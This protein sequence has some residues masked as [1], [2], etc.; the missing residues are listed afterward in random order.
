[1]RF[2]IS[3]SIKVGAVILFF[4]ILLFSQGLKLNT[5]T[6]E[7]KADDKKLF[8]IPFERII[9]IDKRFD[10]SK[11]GYVRT[12][13]EYRE[14]VLNKS[15]STS[16][17]HYLNNRFESA[18]NS[19]NLVVFIKSLWL[20]EVRLGEITKETELDEKKNISQCIVKA[21]I[22]SFSDNIY[23]ALV[24]IDTL[25]ENARPLKNISEEFISSAIDNIIVQVQTLNTEES[26]LRKTKIQKENVFNYY[27]QRFNSLRIK[28][29]TLQK[30]IYLTFADFIN[31]RP[32][33][34]DFTVS[35]ENEADFLY[36]QEKGEQKLFTDFW[37]FCDGKTHFIKVGYNFFKLIK[38]GKTYSLWGCLEP[39]HK[40]KQYAGMENV[41]ADIL[42]GR[43]PNTSRQVSKLKNV[44]RPMQIDMDTG[45]PY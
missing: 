32:S 26:L 23:Q 24:R 12:A 14:A 8:R 1:M 17:E 3:I 27:E 4:P 21:D 43:T 22:Y 45:E 29:D 37:G 7:L 42:T 38:D 30:G 28:N 6:V 10:T 11:I 33:L 19:R 5:L 13:F 36:I 34:I 2:S 16:L 44:L 39:I 18:H 15:F 31:N 41:A 9:V 35:Q 20:Q 25:F 40:R